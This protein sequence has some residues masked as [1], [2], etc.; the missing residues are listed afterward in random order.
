MR[1]QFIHRDGLLHPLCRAKE[2]ASLTDS[3]KFVTCMSCRRFA[4]PRASLTPDL[5]Q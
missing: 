2:P 4:R 3:W 5:S 1:D